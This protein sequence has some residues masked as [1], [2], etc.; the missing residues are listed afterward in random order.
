MDF[1]VDETCLCSSFWLLGFTLPG[2]AS[3]LPDRPYEIG[4]ISSAMQRLI[5]FTFDDL[6]EDEARFFWLL[7]FDTESS[8]LYLYSYLLFYLIDP[9]VFIVDLLT[10]GVLDTVPL[11]LIILENDDGL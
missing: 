8:L 1:L 11:S 4:S 5:V 3:Y 7:F 2:L 6:I 10:F 9:E